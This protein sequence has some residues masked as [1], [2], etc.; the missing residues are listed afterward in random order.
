MVD[1]I[2][3]EQKKARAIVRY[4]RI[5]PRKVRLVIN[6]IRHKPIAT[7]VSTL[8]ALNKKAARLVEKGLKSAVANAKAR[9]LQEER[10]V[11][12]DIRAD[13]GPMFKRVMAR[14]MGR[15]DQ[16]LRRTTHL[17]IVLQETEK[18]F[19]PSRV[20]ETEKEEKKALTTEKLKKARG[21][22]SSKKTKK[23]VKVSR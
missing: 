17:T 19:G 10:L 5:S 16:M 1:T 4:L 20:S 23:M 21:S 12:S 18:H 14:A 13:G 8:S 7:A 3:P 11:V 22:A 6:T 2:L 9:G 15:A